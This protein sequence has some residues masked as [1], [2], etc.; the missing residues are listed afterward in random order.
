ME[1]DWFHLAVE[2]V[3]EKGQGCGLK[4]NERHQNGTRPK[5]NSLCCPFRPRLA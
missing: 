1:E 4:K 2:G 3:D 5:E